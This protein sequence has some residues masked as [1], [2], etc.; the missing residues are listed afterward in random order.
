MYPKAQNIPWRLSNPRR[1]AS[2]TWHFSQLSAGKFASL[3]TQTLSSAHSRAAFSMQSDVDAVVV[4][5]DSDSARTLVRLRLHLLSLSVPPSRE[6]DRKTRDARG[7]LVARTSGKRT[8]GGGISGAHD[9]RW[10]V[11][12]TEI[13]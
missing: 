11:M 5:V 12:A 6:I 1:P 13:S 7:S 2:I 3:F 10:L 8:G 4:V 9:L